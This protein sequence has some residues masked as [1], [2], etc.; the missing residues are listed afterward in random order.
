MFSNFLAGFILIG[1][2]I[3][4][5][6]ALFAMGDKSHKRRWKNIR[7]RIPINTDET[8][9]PFQLKLLIKIGLVLL[10]IG[11]IRWIWF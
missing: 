8:S 11:T 6:A 7:K 1:V 5:L 10:M 2:A 4:E 3:L 9:I